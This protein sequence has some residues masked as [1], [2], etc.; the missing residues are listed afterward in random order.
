MSGL[1]SS[2]YPPDSEAR[3]WLQWLGGIGR[4]V[5]GM[6]TKFQNARQFTRI[7]QKVLLMDFSYGNLMA[8]AQTVPHLNTVISKG[9]EMFSNAIVR[10]VD[11]N[12]KDVTNSDV[13]KL[14]NNPNP[15]DGSFQALMYKFYANNAVYN[16]SFFYK[17][18]G[19]AKEYRGK[20]LPSLLWCLPS[21]EVKINLSGKIYRQPSI[22]DIILDYVLF[23]DPE[24]YMPDEIIYVTEGIT[25]NGISSGN[26]IEALQIELSNIMMA[27]KSLNIILGDR[28]MIGFFTTE[29]KDESGALPIKNTLKK[30]IKDTYQRQ[31]SVDSNESHIGIFTQKTEFHPMTFDVAQ[32]QILPQLEDSFCN[33]CAAFG[34]DRDIFP[35]T[36][37][38]TFENKE[39]GLKQTY[40][41]T[42]QPLANKLMARFT[43]EFGLAE[44]GER[45]I[46]D[47]SWLPVMKDD[48]LAAEK[49][50]FQKVAALSQLLHDGIISPQQYADIAEVKMDGSGEVI[51]APVAKTKPDTSDSGNNE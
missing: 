42:M 7:N 31:N 32:L 45:L 41:N 50:Y 4:A 14:L 11:K 21:G 1:I 9:A 47:Y 15:I 17:N 26:R 2:D 25:A 40:Q 12:G 13:L 36:K 16:N 46:A 38:A 22:E 44:K 30:R 51:Q 34:I 28:G 19:R 6:S 8:I 48:A 27:L 43:A 20:D 3:S 24:P 35:S 5:L 39:Q 10:H 29:S 37:G 33:I 23:L 49:A 18:Y